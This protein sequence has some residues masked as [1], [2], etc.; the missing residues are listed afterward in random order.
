M[1]Q[2]NLTQELRNPA[3]DYVLGNGAQEQNRLKLQAGIL[4]KW[5]EGFFGAAGIGPGM[6]V[7]DLGCGMGDVSLLTARLVGPTGSVIGIDRD[8]VIVRKAR[9]R[10]CREGH[11]ANIEVMCSD[12]LEFD[13]PSSFDAVVGR[14]ILLYQPDPVTAVRHA[15]KQVRSGGIVLFHEMDFANPI[16]SYPDGTL[17]ARL[18]Y[19]LI[20][21]TFRRAGCHADLGLHLTRIFRE[22]GLPWPTIKA[23]VP[24]GGGPS[25]FLYTWLA[26]TL[27]SLLP[28]IEQFNLASAEQLDLD[29]LTAR[30]ETEAVA[31][32]CQLIGPLQFGAWTRKPECGAPC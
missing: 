9:E 13:A 8:E 29:S 11:R 25:C 14:Y 10:V 31:S 21:D 30:M 27:R 3:Q 18:L 32:H 4:E 6:K 24:I 20:T 15:A 23:E 5:T 28:R 2:P 22:A 1:S 12:V 19:G 7:L 17:F 26:E 16:R